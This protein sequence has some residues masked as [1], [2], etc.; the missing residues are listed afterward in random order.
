MCHSTGSE[1]RPRTGQ[2]DPVQRVEARRREEERIE[3]EEQ[4]EEG[5]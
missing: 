2:E 1:A 5:K 4:Q 3:K